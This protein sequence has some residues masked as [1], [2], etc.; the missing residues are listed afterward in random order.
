MLQ[1]SHHVQDIYN[2]DIAFDIFLLDSL[3]SDKMNKAKK[4]EQHAL[5][6]S[7]ALDV[8]VYV[9]CQC[10]LRLEDSIGHNETSSKPDVPA[11]QVL[12]LMEH[13]CLL[14][15]VICESGLST[16][17]NL[18]LRRKL[19][20]SLHVEVWFNRS[21]AVLC[22]AQASGI[23]ADTH[24]VC[25]YVLIHFLFVINMSSPFV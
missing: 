19:T 8:M 13:C 14:L 15:T 9:F 24:E 23:V 10:T 3:V 25:F 6:A 1:V 4:K 17:I 2:L 16:D 21:L 22:S 5:I 12:F 20:S 7:M 11:S 18:L